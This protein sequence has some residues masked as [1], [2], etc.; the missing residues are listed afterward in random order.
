MY[1]LG[2][3]GE[4]GGIKRKGNKILL[5]QGSSMLNDITVTPISLSYGQPAQ[6]SSKIK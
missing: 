1:S 3:E 4:R 5:T 6:P 2:G